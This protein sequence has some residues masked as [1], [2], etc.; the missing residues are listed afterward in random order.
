MTTRRIFLAS[1]AA[2]CAPLPFS[3]RASAQTSPQAGALAGDIAVLREAYET[4]HPGLYRYSTPA[5]LSAHFETLTRAW[6]RGRSLPQ[7]YLS[8]SRFLATIQCGHTYANF[9]NQAPAI[10]AELFD[11][12]PRLPFHFLW[13]D[14]SMVVERNFS[15]DPRL[16]PGAE[17]L[18]IDG[19]P[20]SEILLALLP[21]ARA[22]GA[23]HDKRQ[24][25]LEVRGFD[26]YETFDVFY[27]LH[28]H[29]GSRFEL[30]V[31]PAE[32]RRARAV[33]VAAIDLTA[34]RAN[35]RNTE[36]TNEG[37]GWTLTFPQPRTAM[38][39]MPN[40][41]MYNTSWEW[42]GF[43][44]SSF[45][46]IAAS[47][48]TKLIVDIRGNEGGNDCGDEIVARLIDA[49]VSREGFARRVRYRQT[50]PTLDA[51]L[52][53]WNDS[54]RNWGEDAIPAPNAGYYDLRGETDDGRIAPRGPRFTGEVLVLIDA[55]NS[56]ATFQ[57]AQC[58]RNNRLG[59]LI[60]QSTGG[61]QNGINGGAFFFLRLPASGLE[62]DLP[63]IGYFPNSPK[64]NAGL[65]PDIVV[66]RS[67]ADLAHGRDATLATALAL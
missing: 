48:A 49:P 25:L 56:S 1:A 19:R 29:P 11:A 7:A 54:F 36:V 55:Q 22:D 33:G 62:A 37:A 24:A 28:F 66:E 13:L 23:N 39:T 14:G 65:A 41:V 20:T 60:G 30:R 8:L 5:Q 61:N 2:A 18:S 64:P 12:A 3:R 57:F 31:R 58:I 67:A 27:G 42:R 50:P 16:D 52:D 10:Q 26:S 35:M 15:G 40:W 51:Y 59:R 63:L 6:E 9:Y 34:R 4:L 45:G 46:E 53:T 17:I 44:D 21:Y 47:G 32:E 43:L 38:L